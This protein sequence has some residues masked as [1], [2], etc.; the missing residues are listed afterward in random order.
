MCEGNV[1]N[2][3]GKWITQKRRYAIYLRDEHSCVYCG[4]NITKLI[5]YTLDHRVP[6]DLGGGNETTNLVTACK[7][8]NS[9]KGTKSVSEFLRWLAAEKG[10]DVEDTRKRIR[11]NIKRK[12]IK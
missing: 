9:V 1:A 11:R 5:D 8:C 4:M 6:Q 7:C 10:V 3:G 12:L 2:N